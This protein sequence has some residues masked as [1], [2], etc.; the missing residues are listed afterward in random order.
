MK[1]PVQPPSSLPRVPVPDK[2]RWSVREVCEMC[3]LSRNFLVELERKGEFPPHIWVR[4]GPEH[5]GGKFQ[6]VAAEVRVWSAGGDWKAMVEAR[7]R[8]ER[9]AS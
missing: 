7:C 4:T 2:L 6:Y 8:S 5:S 9:H 3:G 1:K